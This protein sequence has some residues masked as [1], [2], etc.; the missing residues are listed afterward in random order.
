VVAGLA[1]AGE[2]FARAAVERT[3]RTEVIAALG[4]PADQQL[5]VETDGIMLW[6]LATGR[7]DRVQLSSD[8]VT[9]GPLRGAAEVTVEGL[10]LRGGELGAA[11]GRFRID[12]GA[13]FDLISAAL[14]AALPLESLSI[15]AP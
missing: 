2:L 3:I 12:D 6:Q 8:D 7:L 11:E 14:P 10:P 4:L 15:Q 13:L 5:D 9:A 1:V